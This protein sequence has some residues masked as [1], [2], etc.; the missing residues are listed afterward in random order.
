MSRTAFPTRI[1][2]LPGARRRSALFV[3]AATLAIALSST[4]ARAQCAGDTQVLCA[5][6]SDPFVMTVPNGTVTVQPGATVGS[7]T[8]ADAA[9]RFD[10]SGKLI[11]N[12]SA[13]SQGA[14]VQLAD[15][16]SLDVRIGR[17]GTLSG[18]NALRQSDDQGNYIRLENSGLV[19]GT[20]GAAVRA[21]SASL[22]LSNRAGG[23]IE[24]G[25]DV[26]DVYGTN[27]GTIEAGDASAIRAINVDLDNRG[28]V[29]NNSATE[30]TISTESGE[31]ENSGVIEARG[32]APAIAADYLALKNNAGGVI[33]SAGD[34]AIQVAGTARIENAGQ[35]VGDVRSDEYF[36]S[37]YQRAGGSVTGTVSLGGGDDQFW[38]EG[39]ATGFAALP[40]GGVDGGE[41]VDTYG[42]RMTG[43]GAIAFDPLP[44]GFERYGIDLCGC[45]LNVTISAGSLTGGLDVTGPGI[46]TNLADFTYSGYQPGL[47]LDSYSE[48]SDRS[49]PL[50]FVNRGTLN[51]TGVTDPEAGSPLAMIEADDFLTRFTNDTDGTINFSGDAYSGI[52]TRGIG[53]AEGEYG[54]ANRGAIH[55]EGNVSFAVYAQGSAY[56]SGTI[57]NDSAGG[58]AVSLEGPYAS[59]VND[60]GGEL[61]GE[62]AVDMAYGASLTNRGSIVGTGENAAITGYS[63]QYT[64]NLKLINEGEIR[65]EQ[66][67]AVDLYT[68]APS[69]ALVANKG[70]IVGD[71]LLRGTGNDTVWLAEGSAIQGNLSTGDGDDKLVVD[72]GRLKQDGT[73][74]TSGLVSGT[75]DMGAGN[76]V[77]QARAGSSQTFSVL[78]DPVTGFSGGTVY[79]AAGAD[80]VLTLQGPLDA[81]GEGHQSYDGLIRLTGDGRIVL[82]M[83]FNNA[84]Y[85]RPSILVERSSTADLFGDN[86]QGLDL[87]IGATVSGG[88]T[89]IAVDATYARRLEL[90]AQKGGIGFTGGVGLKTGYGTEVVLSNSTEI[91]KSGSAKGTLLV[92]NGSTIFNRTGL[93]E[94]SKTAT[95]DNV[96]TAVDMTDSTLNNERGNLGTGRI[97][98]LGT[99]VRMDNSVVNNTG[100]IISAYGNAIETTGYGV[101]RIINNKNGLIQGHRDGSVVGT[102]GAAIVGGDSNDIVENAGT[103]TG[104]VL[105][106]GG[107]DLYVANGGK[108]TGNLDMGDGDDTVLTRNGSTID[109]SGTVTGGDGADAIGRS[110]TA[111]GTFDLATNTLGNSFEMH[112]VEASGATTEVTVTS[113]TTQTAAL[114]ILGDGKVT[115][116]ASFD[117]ADKDD[118][119]SAAIDASDP[120]GEANLQLVN[121]GT[122]NSALYGVTSS[123]GLASFINTAAINARNTGV[124]IDRY[125]IGAFTMTNSGAITS[126]EGRGL[127]VAAESFGDDSSLAAP[128]N[129]IEV[130]N[131]GSISSGVA[132]DDAVSLYSEYGGVKFGNS[133]TISAASNYASGARVA[134][135]TFDVTNSGTIRSDGKG[136]TGLLLTAFGGL[137][138]E[139]CVDPTPVLVG[140][141]ANTGKIT[142]NGGGSNAGSAPDVATGVFAALRGDYGIVRMNNAAGGSIEAT[143]GLSTALMVAG[144][145]D[146]GYGSTSVDAALRFFE[147]D[148]LG[149]IRGGADTVMQGDSNFDASGVD[150]NAPETAEGADSYAVAGGIQT[151]NTTDKIRNLAGG[152]IIGNVDLADGNDVF[153]NYGTLQGDLRLGEGDDTFVYAASGTFTGTAYGGT[154]ND[155]LLVDVNGGGTVDFD[156]F[157]QFETLSQRGTGS[158]T[159]RGTT[160][161]DTLSMA[162]SNVTVAAG[163]RFQTQGATALTGSDAAEAVN[164]SGTIGGGLAMGGGNDTVT[165][166]A[167]GVVEG[168]IDLGAG[169]DRL[170]LAGGTATGLV[171]GGDG[172]DTVAFEITQDTSNLPNVTNFESLDVS[173]NARLTIGMNQDFDTVTLRNGADLTLNEGTGNHHI[174]NIIGDDSAQSVILNTALTGGVSLGGGDDSLTMSLVGTLSG[175]LDGGAGNDVLNLNLTGDSK[176]AGGIASFE[177]INVAGGSTLTLGSTI[178]AD[179]TLNF[180]EHDNKL[181][182]EGGSILGTVNGG[183]GHD[184]LEFTTLAEQTA[185][186]ATAKIL[187]FEDILANGAGTLAISG[188]GTFQTISVEQGNLTVA[189]G[190]TVTATETN[191]G[192]ANN[193][194]TLASGA[195]LSGAIDGGDG[196]DRLVLN[197]AADTV[198]KLSS[199]NATGFEQLESGDAGELLVDRDASFD[200][201]D[202]FGAKL[203]VAAGSTLTVPTLA[204]NDGA[205]TLNVQGTL[206][207]NVALGAGDDRL[208]LGHSGAITGTASGGTGYD[209]LEFNTQGTYAAPTA[210]NGQGYSEFEAFNVAGGVISLTGNVSYDTISV[211]GG[212]LIGQAG[213]TITSAKTLVVSHGAT[214]GTAGTVNANIEVRGTLSPGASPGTMTVNGNVLFTNGSNLLLEMAPTG[215][216][217][218]NISGAMT[219]QN[220]ATLDITGMLQSTPGG[221]LDLVVAQGGIT[222]GFTTINKSNTV[223]GFV[224]TRGNKIQLVGEFQNDSGFG[225]NVQDSIRYANVV[226][227]GGQMVQAFTGALPALVDTNGASRAAGFAQLSPE[228]FAAAEQASI[229]TGLAVVDA[230]RTLERSNKGQVGFYGFAQGLYQE[231]ALNGNV[232]TGAHDLRSDSRGLLGGFG[233]GMSEN[234]RVTAFVGNLSTNQTVEGLGASTKLDGMQVGVTA[235]GESGAFAIRGMLA[236]DLSRA[237]TRRAL[238]GGT[239]TSRYDLGGLLAD[240]S[241]DYQVSLGAL[242]I[243]PRVGLT[244]VQ[245]RREQAAEKGS[246]FALATLA[247]KSDALFGDASLAVSYDLGGVTPWVEAGVRHQ[248][249]G[250]NGLAYAYFAGVA[251]KGT[252][253]AQGAERGDTMAHLALG[254]TAPLSKSVRL[255]VSYSGEYGAGVGNKFGDTTRHSVNAGLSVAF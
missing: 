89:G 55:A 241:A 155:T 229:D 244:F 192:A 127:F 221:A 15:T 178:A 243:A 131:S 168:S 97:T 35:I 120:R 233:Y 124:Y 2:V 181:I 138:E 184:V 132:G 63:N 106:G 75:L 12:G 199:V 21:R 150:L 93:R 231:G 207:G 32:T 144:L 167:G 117:I 164:V 5:G 135:N 51:F 130:S 22:E 136:G 81:D 13:L 156:Q 95:A 19:R 1:P 76:N 115:N 238:P 152:T 239:A 216:D 183:A 197:Q 41:G 250:D 92:A 196:T 103:I 163:T 99:G 162:G 186:L 40:T 30:A 217:R 236:Y 142:A 210:W 204:G 176:I 60:T 219:I 110:F 53:F 91:R 159:I 46:V 57:R 203:T 33:R 109:V 54:F 175:A 225:T 104:H 111:S 232:G 218:L 228:A 209:T 112:G 48:Y 80:T 254:V 70:S 101:N 147:L 100:D 143:G 145:D 17:A 90:M 9:L 116:N 31:I 246:D 160:D 248:I 61:R 177:T 39:G 126:T 226:L 25:V 121:N 119:V 255:N 98:V 128:G 169:N 36:D 237:K 193:V 140:T 198:R 16:A 77:L 27:N 222:G 149:T 211:T 74:D 67:V 171:D 28:T 220:G 105:L 202:L 107:N 29:A 134:G 191:F 43:S 64:G 50:T 44:S 195:T 137:G 146:E 190:S 215:S 223:F 49:G 154:G 214:F 62:S 252:V 157:R 34:V 96:S 253:I 58:Y 158:I 187:N 8:T 174:G 139:D 20:D 170:V 230:V 165:L 224:A 84:G 235:S 26:Y 227:G 79:E 102:A 206:A 249:G 85:A 114:R 213:T 88:T 94:D 38:R 65:G 118:G 129:S 86:S 6:Q 3:S 37:F 69:G 251:D 242:R 148:N 72:L 52:N 122:I 125:G 189:A 234:A 24:G 10:V 208:T 188:N 83:P 240:V 200:V 245:G 66:G 68:V 113:A 201:V 18:A 23:R 212:R 42:V 59:F 179:Q 194:L 47:S 14:A 7:Q 123:N 172:I 151:I 247:H 161:L 182:V 71:V 205:N 166:N 108:V 185:T 180:D 4:A 153:E 78:Q 73:V 87:V 173:G 133:G 45:D 141:L 82:D 11:V 56:N